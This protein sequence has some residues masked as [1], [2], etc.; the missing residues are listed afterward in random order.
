MKIA[1]ISTRFVPS[2]TTGTSLQAAAASMRMAQT[3]ILPVVNQGQLVGTLSERDLVLRGCADGLDPLD[4]TVEQVYDPDPIVCHEDFHLKAALEV[5]RQRHSTWLVVIGEARKIVGVVSLVEL[6]DLLEQLI[7]EESDG[8][9][10][11]Y[12]KRVRGE[13]AGG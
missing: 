3:G 13:D 6:L 12:V 1:E 5:M 11:N 4:A 2:I 10:P 8:P 7:R 9:E